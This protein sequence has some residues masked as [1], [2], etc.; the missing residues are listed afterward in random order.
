[1]TDE[2]TTFDYLKWPYFLAV[3]WLHEITLCKE[4]EIIYE[5]TIP[6]NTCKRGEGAVVKRLL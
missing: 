3:E 5:K 2:L 6:K 4:G 1:M